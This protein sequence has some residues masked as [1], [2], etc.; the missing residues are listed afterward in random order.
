MLIKVIFTWRDDLL[1]R[2]ARKFGMV[3]SHVGLLYGSDIDGW[4]VFEAS[5][6]GIRNLP[7]DEFISAWDEYKTLRPN[8]PLTVDVRKEIV[9]F[10]WGNVGKP[11]GFLLLLKIAWQILKDRFLMRSFTYPSHVCSSL[12]H[13]CFL[14]IGIDLVLG[15]GRLVLPDDIYLSRNLQSDV[16]K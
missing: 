2:L 5:M 15:K 9:A 4:R 3:W 6:W 14:Y 10:A 1:G 7:I 13:E 11:Y 12:V 8:F 16:L